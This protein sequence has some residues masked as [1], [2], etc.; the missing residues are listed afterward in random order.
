MTIHYGGGQ[1]YLSFQGVKIAQVVHGGVTYTVRG[2]IEFVAQ[3]VPEPALAA[4]AL[5]GVSGL[6]AFGRRRA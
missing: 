4:L 1:A 5:A 3:P 6:A 2:N